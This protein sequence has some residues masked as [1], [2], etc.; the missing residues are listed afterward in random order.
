MIIGSIMLQ[1]P[2]DAGVMSVFNK[3]GT[4]EEQLSSFIGRKFFYIPQQV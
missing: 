4:A 3:G 2:A 1:W